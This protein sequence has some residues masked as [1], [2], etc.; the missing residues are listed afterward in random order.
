MIVSNTPFT[1]SRRHLCLLRATIKQVAI[2]CHATKMFSWKLNPSISTTLAPRLCPLSANYFP[3]IMCIW[4]WLW[5]PLCLHSATMTALEQPW[6][7]FCI[8]SDSLMR[9]FVPT[10]LS[11]NGGLSRWHK[12]HMSSHTETRLSG[13][14]DHWASRS[15]FGSLKGGTKVITLCRWGSS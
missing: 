6:R 12:G 11:L 2:G 9:I 8:L 10:T 15:Y 4:Q 1:Q 3:P 14:G 7:W 5:R 13:L